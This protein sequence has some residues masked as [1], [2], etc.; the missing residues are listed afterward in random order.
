MSPK[1][2]GFSRSVLLREVIRT[3]RKNESYI[4][5]EKLLYNYLLKKLC[6]KAIKEF[7]LDFFIIYSN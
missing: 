7:G 1:V 2:K 4:F 6:Y 5:D 3:L